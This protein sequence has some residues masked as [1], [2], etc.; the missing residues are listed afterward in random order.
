MNPT[1]TW[2]KTLPHLYSSKR[3]VLFFRLE[4]KGEKDGVKKYSYHRLKS[5]RLLGAIDEIEREKIYLKNETKNPKEKLHD[6]R[7]CVKA[8]KKISK[9]LEFFSWNGFRGLRYEYCPMTEFILLDRRTLFYNPEKVLGS[10]D[11]DITR[12]L[13]SFVGVL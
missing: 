3:G 7:G 9:A 8:I 10:S 2:V 13:R 4:N 1:T 11:S 5:E 6:L 12:K